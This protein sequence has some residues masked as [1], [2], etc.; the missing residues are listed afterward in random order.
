MYLSKS[1]FQLATSCSQKLLYKKRGYPTAHDTNEY[2]QMLAQNGYLIGHMANMLYPEG[3]EITGNSAEAIEATRIALEQENCI[4]FEAA[5][6]AGQKLV[7]VDILIK[8]GNELHLIEVKSKSH[9][10]DDDAGAQRKKLE[11]YIQDVAYQYLVLSEAYPEM[12]IRASLLMPDKAKRTTIDGLAGWFSIERDTVEDDRENEELPAQQRPRFRK[13]TVRFLYEDHPERAEQVSRLLQ[14]GI[15]SERDVTE[16]VLNLQVAVRAKA[17]QLIQIM[18]NDSA[19]ETFCITKN[20][21]T[22]EFRTPEET[23]NGFGECWGEMATTNPHIFDLYY[24]GALGSAAN[25]F[26]LDELIAEGKSSLFDIDKERLKNAKGFYGSRGERQLI[27]LEYT[28]K[29][30]EWKSEE[31]KNMSGKFSY[32]IFCVDFETYLGAIPF[33]AGMRPY[34]LLAFQ[35]SLHTIEREGAAPIHREWLHDGDGFP[36]FDFAIALMEAIGDSGTPF[37]WATHENTVLKTILDQMDIYGYENDRLKE[38]IVR[39]THDRTTKREGRLVDMNRMTQDHYFHP[40]MKGRTSIKK[41]LPAIWENYPYLHELPHF[42]DY[43]STDSEGMIIDPYDLLAVHG[44]EETGDEV[45]KIGTAAMRAYYRIRFDNSLTD[46][47]REEI[48]KQLKSYCQLDSLAMVLIA[49][50]WGIK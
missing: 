1:D 30:E 50:H 24:G 21:K 40:D 36:N 22:C 48:R 11:K 49:H 25:G 35:W 43:K 31:L 27:Q 44:E 23:L 13:P 32:P 10:T 17:E 45:V 33:H 3:I 9:D 34:E 47:Q 42:S 14:E 4:L 39:M 41:V 29:G 20:C 28:E 19:E 6:T 46:N 2:M 15:L 8:N 37:M 38:W 26:Y 18:N 5:I 7:R 12:N 16:E